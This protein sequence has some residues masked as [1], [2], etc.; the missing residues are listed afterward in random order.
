M[1]AIYEASI[2]ARERRTR[3]A[4]T[5]LARRGRY[6]IHGAWRDGA[7]VAAAVI[8]DCAGAEISLLD[9]LFSREDMR[10]SGLG[11]ALF[12]AVAADLG[13]RRLLVEVDSD[14]EAA[15]DQAIRRRRKDFYRRLGC[16][17]LVGLP[18]ILPLP[19]EGDPPLM[20]L[21]VLGEVR[22][23]VPTVEVRHWL[24]T[25]IGEAYPDVPAEALVAR[26]VGNLGPSIALEA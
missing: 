10:G 18:Y 15:A 13:E 16:R 12:G 21:L 7:L 17:Q 2:P 14:R 1:F 23:T 19:G 9:Y 8:F 6:R 26:M 25:M 20:D 3:A 22:N 11:G 24:L 5:E 4:V